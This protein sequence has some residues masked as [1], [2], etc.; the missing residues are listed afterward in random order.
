MVWVFPVA[1]RFF[2][3]DRQCSRT[4]FGSGAVTSSRIGLSR[5]KNR[6]LRLTREV[7]AIKRNPFF[8]KK[9]PRSQIL[10]FSPEFQYVHFVGNFSVTITCIIFVSKD[11]DNFWIFFRNYLVFSPEFQCLKQKWLWYISDMFFTVLWQFSVL[12]IFFL[13][14]PVS[15]P[16]R[17]WCTI[18]YFE[19]NHR[20]GETSGFFC[21]SVNIDGF[22]EPFDARRL[23][24]GRLSNVNRTHTIEMVR[25]NIGK[26][27]PFSWIIMIDWLIKIV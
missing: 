21:P 2:N 8:G 11:V 20:V 24:L 19:M 15:T 23:C 25:R 13:S 22:T 1:L 16:A 14:G 10:G 27:W 9:G 4:A 6:T 7:S 26:R 3:R 5:S 18:T 12:L 17:C